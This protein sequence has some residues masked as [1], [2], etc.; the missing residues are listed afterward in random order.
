MRFRLTGELLRRAL[1][2]P[3]PIIAVLVLAA[4]VFYFWTGLVD[5]REQPAQVSILQQEPE[6]VPEAEV[7]LIL[8]D[9]AGLE[10]PTFVTVPLPQEPAPRVSSLLA[11]LRTEALA[12]PWPEALPVPQV[13]VETVDRQDIAVLDFRP[14][15]PLTLT[16]EAEARLLR[17]IE[18]TLLENGIDDV[19]Y[20]LEGEAAGVFLEHLAVPAAL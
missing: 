2:R 17:S 12:D 6:S 8:F 18:E 15:E 14:D 13:Y 1:L 4:A 9:A 19:R 7:R 5:N 16:V 11:A 20:L 3:E 10:T